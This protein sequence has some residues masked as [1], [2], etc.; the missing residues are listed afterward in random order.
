[1]EENSFKTADGLRFRCKSCSGQLRYDIGSGRLVCE[2]CGNGYAIT[3]IPDPSLNDCDNCMDTVEYICPSCGAP[4]T[5]FDN[6]DVRCEFCS[7]VVVGEKIWQITE[8]KEK[9]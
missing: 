6:G 4:L 7:T 2:S 5:R 9:P 1:M 8:I 3:S